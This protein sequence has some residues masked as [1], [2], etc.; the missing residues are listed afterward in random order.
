MADACIFCRMV[1]G[2]IPVNKVAE[3]EHCL[4]FRD[5]APQAPQHLLVIPKAHV[6]SLNE[7]TDELTVGRMARLAADVAREQGFAEAGYRTVMNTNRDGGQTVFH[8]HMHVL[9]GRAMHWPP[10]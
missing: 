8:L 7:V 5:I 9:A 6:T 10:G 3:T 1:A 2:E 4:A